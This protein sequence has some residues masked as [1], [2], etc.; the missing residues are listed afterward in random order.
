[1][2]SPKEISLNRYCMHLILNDSVRF[3][4][5]VVGTR[6]GWGQCA[7]VRAL[8]SDRLSPLATPQLALALSKTMGQ[9]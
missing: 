1:M 8:E 5:G 9:I 6:V 7:L 4:F 3:K 2:K